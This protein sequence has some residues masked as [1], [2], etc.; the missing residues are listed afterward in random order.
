MS[1]DEREPPERSKLRMPGRNFFEHAIVLNITLYYFERLDLSPPM[2]PRAPT[3]PLCALRP[4]VCAV[5]ACR[6]GQC[7]CRGR[8]GRRAGLPLVFCSSM[9]LP[10]VLPWSYLVLP[11]SLVLPTVLHGR[12]RSHPRMHTKPPETRPQRAT[13]GACVSMAAWPRALEPA[14][15]ESGTQ[16]PGA[17]PGGKR[18][19]APARG[20]RGL[21]GG[22]V[23]GGITRFT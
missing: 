16:Q 3:S 19:P 10:L 14:G 21:G 23:W 12:G 4:A 18:S 7:R 9:G 2:C 11:C 15:A 20:G 5:R 8:S 13:M 17:G 1:A 6:P 22:S